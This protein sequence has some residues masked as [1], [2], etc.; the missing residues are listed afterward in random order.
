M[1]VSDSLWE[2]P[3]SRWPG[4]VVAM[5]AAWL[6][7]NC[8][9]AAVPLW[10]PLPGQLR[11]P[12]LIINIA[13][14]DAGS[15]ALARLRRVPPSPT[16]FQAQKLLRDLGHYRGSVNGLL[17]AATSAAVKRYQRRTNL[18]V[19]GLV[20][21]ALLDHLEFTGRAE[22]LVE[23]LSQVRSQQV[24]RARA[25]LA[26]QPETRSLLAGRAAD[27][28]ADP[29][30]DSAACFA[31]PSV[32]CLLEE[33]LEAAKAVHRAHFRDWV[34]GEILQ[35]QARLGRDDEALATAARID[36]PRLVMTALGKIAR[37][38]ARQRRWQAAG[39]TA[40]LIPDP[41]VRAGV[42]VALVAALAEAER[43]AAAYDAASE[44]AALLERI[45]AGR[46]RLEVLSGL[47]LALEAPPPAEP[48]PVL[49]ALAEKFVARA[50]AAVEAG[51]PGA[52]RRVAQ[53]MARRGRPGAALA[54][55]EE[56]ADADQRD[57]LMADIALAQARLGQDQAALASVAQVA[58]PRYRIAALV[59]IANLHSAA[60]R[61]GAAR[62][63]LA[64]A[65]PEIDNIEAKFSYA[66]ADAGNR[67]VHALIDAGA[68]A[69][70]RR[71]AGAI[72][73]ARLRADAQWRLAAAAA[74][75]ARTG[76]TGAAAAERLSRDLTGAIGNALDR[77]WTS[78]NGVRAGLNAGARPLARRTFELALETVREISSP[79]ARAQALVRLAATLSALEEN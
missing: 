62:A 27:E 26:A 78:C 65:L 35:L 50:L 2:M 21:E 42:L 75:A 20:S 53:L 55:A 29:A 5:L 11:P 8:A 66:R 56:L 14:N 58:P 51:L 71:T 72:G 3:G 67:L 43:V 37:A 31:A 77:A 10:P 70:A 16:V 74:A 15:D 22:R 68:G 33:A 7:L 69:E 38:Q 73:D 18:E 41:Q 24:A 48:P 46:A 79:W 9:A 47:V 59:R 32:S 61:P 1:R 57:V 17:D 6:G 40:R 13:L 4:A 44:A 64:R 19:D 23:R 30:R 12:P 34:L 52:R 54:L 60:E 63:V 49:G 28:A 45:A 36:D 39:A 76:A 25:A